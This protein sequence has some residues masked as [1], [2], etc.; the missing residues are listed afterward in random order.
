MRKTK[1]TAY[2]ALVCISALAVAAFASASTSTIS[3]RKTAVGKVLVG[4]N[5]RT[6]YLFT[7][8]K[9]NTSNCYGQC[10]TFW[11]PLIAS[12]KPR[13]GAGVKASL[14]GT[15]KRADGR[16]QVTYNHHPLYT[17]IKDT[18]KGQTNGEGLNAFGGVWDAVSSAGAKVVKANAAPAPA[19]SG[20]GV[21]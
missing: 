1:L 20:N 19:T 12:A 6:V 13:A 14:L 11:P 3:L 7:A 18:K 15:T 16:L 8:D 5:G 10:A 4:G 17:F 2:V 9:G 21:Y